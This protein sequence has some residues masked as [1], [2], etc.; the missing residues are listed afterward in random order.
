MCAQAGREAA[1]HAAMAAEQQLVAGRS[2]R[3]SLQALLLQQCHAGCSQLH[4]PSAAED[5]FPTP[6]VC[7]DD[8][9]EAL[10][11]VAALQQPQAAKLLDALQDIPHQ[12]KHLQSQDRG[13]AEEAAVQG[14]NA[15]GTAASPV[16]TLQRLLSMTGCTSLQ[17]LLQHVQALVQASASLCEAEQQA[18]LGTSEH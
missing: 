3:R 2:S 11:G 10:Q 15:H 17:Q 5:G 9:W 14:A 12:Q 7:A 18:V 6:A 4:N 13:E 16:E 1:K 8:L